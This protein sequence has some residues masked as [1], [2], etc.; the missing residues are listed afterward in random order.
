MTMGSTYSFQWHIA[1]VDLVRLTCVKIPM[2]GVYTLPCTTLD[3]VVYE[4][5]LIDPSVDDSKGARST[6][7]RFRAKKAPKGILTHEERTVGFG[8]RSVRLR[9][10]AHWQ[11][12]NN[13][14]TTKYKLSKYLKFYIISKRSICTNHHSRNTPGW[15]THPRARRYIPSENCRRRTPVL[16]C[17]TR[18][19]PPCALHTLN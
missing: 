12:T 3:L 17:D 18:C 8:A 5:P 4:V 19:T 11:C 14:V 9:A 6:K 1:Y 16:D 10:I 13:E 2:V 15:N 7:A